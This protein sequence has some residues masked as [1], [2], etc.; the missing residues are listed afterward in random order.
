VL[1]RKSLL[2]FT[3]NIIGSAFGFLST[4]VIARWM[5]PEAL[6][7]IGYLLGLLGL[8]AV[9]LDMGSGLAH[10]KRV[11]ETDGDP[12]PQI[13]TFLAIRS[14]LAVVFLLAVV[15]LPVIRDALR[16]GQPLFQTGD[17]RY[18]YWVI[19]AY[20]VLNSLASVFLY[21][22]EARL[23]TAKESVADFVGSVVPFVAK[24]A[25]A[26]SGLG[27]TALSVAYLTEGVVRLVAALAFFGG[28]HVARVRREH[29]LSYIRYA[30]PLTLNTALS[31]IVSNVNPVLL[32]ASWTSVEV[33]YYTSVLGFGVVLE[34][35]A[36]T[37]MVLFFP[38]ASSDVARGAWD[39]VRRRV[40]VIEHY[41]LTVLVPLAVVF[42]FFS[43]QIVTVALGAKFSPATSILVCL[44]INSTVTA[45]F[46]P[47]R[48][49][50]YAI[51]KQ[52]I[53]VWS[54]LVG[55]MALLVVDVL[56]VP[57]QLGGLT[58][59]GLGGA[60]AAIGLLAMTVSSGMLQV[61]A[62]KQRAG[63]GFY[64]KAALHLL[65]GGIM[66][67][68]MWILGRVAPASLWLRVPLLALLGPAVY[69]LALAVMGQFTLVDARVFLNMLHPRR[70]LEYISSELDRSG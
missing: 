27:V 12:A 37:V 21:T 20:Y 43:E 50:L 58:L 19:A 13:G 28:Y 2:F 39:E 25:V 69:L 41:V 47:Y 63:I 1:A 40:S 52:G 23:E 49:V 59:A 66:Y 67:A 68:A 55:L 15:L 62:V 33:G 64:W 35:V 24:A 4:L 61:R 60:G 51:E 70:M 30:L 65:A 32:K 36:S 22:F 42:I 53:L 57:H 16:L 17:E 10:L 44:A 11:S 3:V 9:L 38:Q 56:L 8:L 31:M 46:Q 26:F 5:G 7:T 54:N 6:G 48:A 18:A 34:R 14:V 29:L 45:I